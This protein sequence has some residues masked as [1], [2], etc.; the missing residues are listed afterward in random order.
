MK[1][2][3]KICL[4]IVVIGIIISTIFTIY[5]FS[6]PNEICGTIIQI[7]K[8]IGA[9]SYKG[10]DY[11]YMDVRYIDRCGNIKDTILGFPII[12]KRMEGGGFNSHGI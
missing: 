8:R 2:I 11:Y 3:N 12:T 10:K 6:Q 1:K 4:F 7:D 9:F 5:L